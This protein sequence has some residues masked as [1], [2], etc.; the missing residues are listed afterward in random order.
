MEEEFFSLEIHNKSKFS[1]KKDEDF[2]HLK[3][4]INIVDFLNFILSLETLIFL[5]ERYCN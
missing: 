5:N 2:F 1:E 4:I 3:S